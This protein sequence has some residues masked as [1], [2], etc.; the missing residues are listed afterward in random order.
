MKKIPDTKI[1]S[2]ED[3][4]KEF[5][6]KFDNSINIEFVGK[7]KYEEMISEY[8]NYIHNTCEEIAFPHKKP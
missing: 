5:Q 3:I 4:E 7:D 6:L 8:D 2:R 1:Q